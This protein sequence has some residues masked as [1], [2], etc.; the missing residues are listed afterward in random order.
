MLFWGQ[1]WREVLNAKVGESITILA[2]TVDDQFNKAD[3]V[4]SGIFHTGVKEF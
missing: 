3:V 1:A 2:R 4:V